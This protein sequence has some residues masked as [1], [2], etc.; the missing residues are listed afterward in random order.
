[1]N[2]TRDPVFPA[3][4]QL[5]NTLPNIGRD[6]RA[7]K[8]APVFGPRPPSQGALQRRD[9]SD[10]SSCKFTNS[11]PVRYTYLP[12]VQTQSEITNCNSGQDFGGAPCNF[13]QGFTGSVQLMSSQSLSLSESIQVGVEGIFS[14][15]TTFGW[16]GGASATNGQDI[17]A[18][19]TQTLPQGRSGYPSFKQVVQCKRCLLSHAVLAA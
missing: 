6:I 3:A 8:S 14:S 4:P 5:S 18:S 15:T 7:V 13:E 19:Y 10:V 9:D 12:S 16:D 11:T 2:G 17:S 1:M